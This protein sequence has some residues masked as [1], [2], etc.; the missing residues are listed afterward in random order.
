MIRISLILISIF[1]LLYGLVFLLI[2]YYFTE[3]TEADN[4][5]TKDNLL[6]SILAGVSINRLTQ[7]FPNHKCVRVVTNIPITVG[8]C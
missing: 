2:P 7:K 5:K 8:K 4:I 3:L 1:S 6:V